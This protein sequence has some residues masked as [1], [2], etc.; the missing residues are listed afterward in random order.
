MPST[1]GLRA[2]LQARRYFN[3]KCKHGVWRGGT[4][5]WYLLYL[6]DTSW[7]HSAPRTLEQGG[8]SRPALGGRYKLRFTERGTSELA[9]EGCMD[10]LQAGGLASATRE[11]RGLPD[12]LLH[13]WC[14]AQF[15]A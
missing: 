5:S 10:S 14:E 6:L 15:L 4:S 3:T 13:R 12:L 1:P 8:V 7:S 2:A 11:R 9:L